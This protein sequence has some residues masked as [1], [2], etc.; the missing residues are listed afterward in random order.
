MIIA[1]FLLRV[2]VKDCDNR[3]MIGIVRVRFLYFCLHLEGASCPSS[4]MV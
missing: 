3:D 1:S 2:H 4:F